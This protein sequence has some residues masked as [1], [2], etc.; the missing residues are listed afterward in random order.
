MNRV[1]RF[2]I[3]AFLLSTLIMATSPALRAQAKVA[4]VEI[5]GPATEAVA[6][7]KMK[8]IATAKDETGKALDMKPSFWVALPVDSAAA[9]ETGT[10]TF[11]EPGEI[12]VVAIVGGKPGFVTVNVKPAGV[13]RIDV[14]PATAQVLVGGTLKLNATARVPNGDP[15]SDVVVAWTSDTPRV[16]TVDAAG[17]VTGVAPGKATLRATAGSANKT[18][19]VQVVANS[20]R[21]LSVI[22]STTTAKT[23]DVVHFVA[24]AKNLRGG[25][26]QNPSVRWAVTGDGAIIYTDGGF[27]AERPGSYIV[28]AAS[29]N[30]SASASIVVAPRNVARDLKVVGHEVLKD[31]QAAEQWIFGNYAYVST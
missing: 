16:A 14:E 10:V 24:R 15:R 13:S 17:F 18:V 20:V 29:G 1:Y 12:K 3:K 11:L 21:S 5:T 9:D 8:F 2:A 23:G 22:P 28:T 31:V 27:V 4:S 25:D 6:G 26:V 7:Q 19:M 30:Q